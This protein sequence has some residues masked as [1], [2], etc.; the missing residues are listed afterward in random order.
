[1]HP[2][3]EK[4]TSFR[5]PFGIHFVKIISCLQIRH[6]LR[7]FFFFFQK[8]ECDTFMC[9]FSFI[10]LLVSFC[11]VDE[12]DYLVFFGSYLILILMCPT[13]IMEVGAEKEVNEDL[14]PSHSF[15]FF[16]FLYIYIGS[17]SEFGLDI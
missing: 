3:D 10:S 8:M 5:T 17:G 15:F 7:K 16:P 13:R 6:T 1:M 11:F 4:H 12:Q 2:K 9:F 14:F